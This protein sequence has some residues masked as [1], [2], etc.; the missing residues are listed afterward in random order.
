[1][2]GTFTKCSTT[3][4]VLLATIFFILYNYTQTEPY[5]QTQTQTQKHGPS[6][7]PKLWY[8]T[9]PKGLS[10]QSETW[11]RE[12]LHKNPL[13]DTQILTDET[14]DEYVSYHYA[15][16]PDIVYTYLALQ[17]PILK[18][19]FLRYLLLFAEGGVWSD[20]DVSCE[21]PIAE[22]IPKEY[23]RADVGLVVGWEFDVGWGDNFIRQF[24]SW[25]IMARAGCVHLGV[26]IDEIVAAVRDKGLLFGVGVDGLTIEMVGDIIDLTGPRRLT[27][28]VLRSLEMI[29]GEV[30]D[31][32]SISKLM[33]PALVE[34][35]L[36]L[37]GFAFAASS[38]NYVNGSGVA[39]VTHHYAGS[40]KNHH[41]GEM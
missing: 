10:D 12:C 8:K 25:T 22:Y 24:A 27:G 15:H 7:P 5:I 39:L 9:G 29:R 21:M 4:I 13:H 31:M 35:V 32:E 20:L 3:S 34:D 19:D 30:V 23:Q 37:P 33:E 2:P 41:G 38:N 28:G 36:I 18:A 14:G 1:M 6:I 40:W 17:I 11:L 16:R 26:V